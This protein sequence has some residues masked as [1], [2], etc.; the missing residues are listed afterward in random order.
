MANHHIF[1]SFIPFSEISKSQDDVP[2]PESTRVAE[3]QNPGVGEVSSASKYF[4]CVSSPPKLIH[5][6]NGAKLLGCDTLWVWG[7]LGKNSL[8]MGSGCSAEGK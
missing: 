7:F 1:L 6:S 5:R 3:A 2:Q 4:S 8:D